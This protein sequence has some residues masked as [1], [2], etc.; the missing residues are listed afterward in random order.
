MARTAI[1]DQKKATRQEVIGHLLLATTAVL[2]GSSY[3]STRMIVD[4]VPPLLLGFLRGLLAVLVLG[5]I[6]RWKQAPLR[7]GLRDWLPL[8]GLGA[9]G[10]G[11]FYLGL[12]LALQWTTAVTASLL[13]LPYPALT[14]LCAWAFL[15]ERLRSEQMAGIVLAGVG[16]AWLTLASA[17]E[18]VSGS[19]IGNL[20]ALSITVAWTVYT[21]IGRRVLPRWSPWTAT[22]HVMLAGTILLGIGAGVESLHGSEP[23]WTAE[24]VLLTLYLGF[25]CTGIGYAFWN[26]G[27]QVVPAA[28][29]SVSM[30]LQ[31]LT[32]LLL[33]V[34][35]LG[36]RPTLTTLAAG[37]L[38]LIG[39]ALAARRSGGG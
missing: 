18:S 13:S 35:I 27:L 2:W 38:V 12:N 32:V 25:V 3:I 16:A 1:D 37:G 17:Q 33:A 10:V 26:G 28:T 34:P 8:A 19:W 23:R 24:A 7:I 39:T 5:L 36:E 22:F 20:L 31:P 9:L 14:A 4:G 21:L 30:Y 6:A 11:Y 29:A 15:R